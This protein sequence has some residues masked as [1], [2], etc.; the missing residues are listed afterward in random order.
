[1]D[2]W[3][4]QTGYYSAMSMLE[5][6][7]VSAGE[8]RKISSDMEQ[9]SNNA[10]ESSSSIENAARLSGKRTRVEG[11]EVEHSYDESCTCKNCF[12]KE[13]ILSCQCEG[14]RS[15]N[16]CRSVEMW[17]YL[18]TIGG[19]KKAEENREV[20]EEVCGQE[21]RYAAQ[22]GLAQEP[23][24]VYFGIDTD[25]EGSVQEIDLSADEKLTYPTSPEQSYEDSSSD[26]SI[27]DEDIK[28]YGFQ[29]T[30]FS[31]QQAKADQLYAT[32]KTNGEAS[33]FDVKW[34]GPKDSIWMNSMN[35]LRNMRSP[36]NKFRRHEI[37]NNTGD[38][39]ALRAVYYRQFGQN[40][41]GNFTQIYDVRRNLTLMN[42]VKGMTQNH[43]ICRLMHAMY[44]TMP[45]VIEHNC[46]VSYVDPSEAI[47]AY[48][49]LLG[50]VNIKDSFL[51]TNP[52]TWSP[53]A[54]GEDCI[55]KQRNPMPEPLMNAL[56]NDLQYSRREIPH[57]AGVWGLYP[58]EVVRYN[59]WQI[60]YRLEGSDDCN[61]IVHRGN[62]QEGVLYNRDTVFRAQS[63]Y[64]AMI[65][66]HDVSYRYDNIMLSAIDCVDSLL[67][68][69][70]SAPDEIA[71]SLSRVYG[72]EKR[73]KI[74]R[75]FYPA[76]HT[77]I[78]GLCMHYIAKG[79]LSDED[80]SKIK[81]AVLQWY[82]EE[83]SIYRCNGC[84]VHAM[85]QEV[86]YDLTRDLFSGESH[87]GAG[88]CTTP[89]FIERLLN[90]IFTHDDV[91]GQDESSVVVDTITA[92]MRK[93]YIEVDLF[94][95]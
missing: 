8:K 76:L 26:G 51:V 25:E 82:A 78:Q 67:A 57:D 18:G 42:I 60:L 7:Q 5:L 68:K 37:G 77:C 53:N 34:R 10:D 74:N 79:S 38:N 4:C 93:A 54:C 17:S 55:T 80:Q 27:S 6:Q 94:E 43:S 52:Y 83:W 73:K 63:I 21:V 39:K 49:A 65:V 69:H 71:S 70:N 75:A 47:S 64:K 28:M 20:V 92:V 12:R 50:Y 41:Y 16:K 24:D 31:R 44:E 1:M 59:L 89:S 19:F 81:E 90:D 58:L 33:L 85:G 3:T 61:G 29:L 11:E 86:F 45:T 62:R 2:L 88:G 13:S 56:S 46:D 48:A 72:I 9:L 22:E 23:K 15:G 36:S 95:H 84:D 66:E 32:E 87:L 35:A 91:D 14:C 40:A 30:A